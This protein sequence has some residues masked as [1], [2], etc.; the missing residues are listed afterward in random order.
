M[1]NKYKVDGDV[2]TIFVHKRNGKIY[3]VLVDTEDLNI[4][5]EKASSIQV[6]DCDSV[7]YA[8][9]QCKEDKISK[10]LHRMIMNTPT[11]L[12]VDH[13]DYNG[14]NNKKSNLRNCN[15]SDNS[16]NQRQHKTNTSGVRGV[17]YFPD[18][19]QY[20]AQIVLNGV[21][22]DLGF[23]ETKEEATEVVDK[24]RKTHIEPIKNYYGEIAKIL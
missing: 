16:H 5:I 6:N 1:K 7:N 14:L 20:K 8:K 10:T 3:E 13:I 21:R 17:S 18:Y 4:I 15:K 24:F 9:Y 12:I 19:K 23:Y 11:V 22:H 2:T